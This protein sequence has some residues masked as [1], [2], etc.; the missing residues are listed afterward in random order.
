MKKPLNTKTTTGNNSQR[1]TANG[2]HE[3][4]WTNEWLETNALESNNIETI[5]NL[6]MND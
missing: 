1:L 4:D 6:N 3:N 2:T 5:I